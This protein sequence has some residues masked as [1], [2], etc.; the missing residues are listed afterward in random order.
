MEVVER[1]LSNLVLKELNDSPFSGHLSEDI[2]RERRK[3]WI[4]WTMWKNNVS[5]YCKTCEKSQMSHK[6]TGKRLG[7]MSKIQ[8]PSR[9]WKTVHM[10]WVTGL[11]PGAD[12]SYYSFLVIVERFSKTPMFL[13][14]HKDDIAMNTALLIWNRIVS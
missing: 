14:C 10:D 13:P 7:N 8:E 5:E 2:T 3:N 9:P 1:L 11:P 6:A 4:W 12:R